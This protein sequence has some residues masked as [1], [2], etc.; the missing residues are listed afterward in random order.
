MSGTA[1]SWPPATGPTTKIVP[2]SSAILTLSHKELVHA[3]AS[4]V[5]SAILNVGEYKEWNN[6]VPDVRIDSQPAATSSCPS[7]SPEE[8][9]R[10]LRIGTHMTFSVIMNAS[11][12]QSINTTNLK[13]LD[14]STPEAPSSYLSPQMLDDPTFTADLSKIYRVSWTSAGG[15]M[16]RF[17]QLERFHEVIVMDRD[18]DGKERCEVRTWEAMEGLLARITRW[19]YGETLKEKVGLWVKDLKKWCEE[20]HKNGGGGRA[21]E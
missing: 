8:D 18:F 7:P 3:P 2:R 11:K 4:L 9:G 19:V 5:F 13:V 15:F 21:G 20:Q 1:T 10:M 6:W 12:P 17:L 16:A 14:I